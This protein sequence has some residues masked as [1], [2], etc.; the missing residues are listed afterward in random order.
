MSK[1]VLGLIL[2]AV[3]GAIDGGTAWFT[4]EA[5]AGMVGI[6]IG[7]TIKGMIAGVAAGWFAKKVNNMAAGIVFGL[8][9]GAALAFVIVALNGWKH[10]FAIMLPGTCVGAI[11]GWATQRYGLA[12]S[13]RAA[14]SIAGMLLLAAVSARSLILR[15]CEA[16][17]RI[18]NATAQGV[19]RRVAAQDVRTDTERRIH[20]DAGKAEPMNFRIVS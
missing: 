4:P 17:R 13:S 14:A 3:L 19:L 18:P 8:A 12:K 7:S 11:C 10:A 9:V 1:V 16:G 20:F 2:G 6:I 5:R 15:P